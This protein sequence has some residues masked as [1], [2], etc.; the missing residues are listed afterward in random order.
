VSFWLVLLNAL[1]FEAISARHDPVRLRRHAVA[2]VA[3]FGFVNLYNGVRWFRGI[4]PLGYQEVAVIQPNIPQKIKWDDHY[5]RQILDHM[6]TL[7]AAAATNSTNLVVWPETAIPYHIDESKGFQLMQM[8]TLPQGNT[9]VLTGRKLMLD[10]LQRCNY[11]QNTVRAYIHAVEDFSRYFHRSPDRLGPEQIREYQVHLFRDCKLSPGTIEGRTAALRFLFV[12]TLRRPY[13]SGHIPFPKRQRRMP[14]VLSQEEVARLIASAQNLMHRTMLMLLYPTGLRR[15]ELCH[16]KV[17]DIDSERMVIHV[18][19]GKGGRDRDVLLTPKLLDTLREYWRWM[20]PKTYL[21][22]GT[23]NNWRADVPITEKIVWKAVAEAAK[24]AGVSKHVSPHTLR[25]SFATHML[26]AGADLRTIQILLGHAKLA[27]TTVYLHLSRRHLQAV[28]S[29]LEAIEV[30]GPDQV[31]R[32]RR[33]VK[34]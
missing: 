12:K 21:F 20:K 19:Q 25:H 9:Y 4:A 5:A 27:D 28:P 14:T 7:N 33:L 32:S 22:P 17:C 6:F 18:R 23:V 2:W 31:K 34:R 24:H 1:L 13:L 11:A 10:E 15:A 3:I 26:E 8:G 30:S 16:L 29:P